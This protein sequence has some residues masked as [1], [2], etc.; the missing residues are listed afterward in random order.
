M[1]VYHGFGLYYIVY[2][3]YL[4]VFLRGTINTLE[5]HKFKDFLLVIESEQQELAGHAV[6]G[7]GIIPSVGHFTLLGDALT[8]FS[9]VCPNAVSQTNSLPKT[10]IQVLCIKSL[11]KQY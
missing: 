5:Q 2:M 3:L 4:I 10:E 11:S 9:D 7:P 8:K 1:L 6:R